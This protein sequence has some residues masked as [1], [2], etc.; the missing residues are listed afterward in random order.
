MSRDVS[1]DVAKG[2]AIVC[3]VLGHGDY[4]GAPEGMI[5]LIFTFHMPLFFILSG[6]FMSPEARPDTCYVRECALSLLLQYAVTCAIM[7]L[8]YAVRTLL[9]WPEGLLDVLSTMGVASLYGS[10]T[11]VVPLPDGV[12]MVGAI[13]FL[14]ALFWA[15]LILAAANR[16]PYP[17]AAVLCSFVVGYVSSDILWL[18]LDIQAGAC[19]TLFLYLG[20]RLREKDVLSP[21]S[22]N[23]L[24]WALIAGMWLICVTLGG[25]LTMAAN[26]YPNGPIVDVLGGLCGTLCVVKLSQLIARCLP[27]LGKPLAWLGTITLP[28]FC[29]HLVEMDVF[30]WDRVAEVL[31][32]LPMPLWVGALVVRCALIAVMCGV[33]YALP[34][35]ISGVFYRSR[36]RR[37]KT[38]R[39]RA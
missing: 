17:L 35:P 30:L 7:L 13:W 19:A 32:S 34:R 38:A 24:L 25:K 11:M 5:D 12:T 37:S 28:I 4:F 10:G 6:F 16:S 31:I 1:L 23:P 9:F 18:P 20:Q 21:G 22:L 39:M 36:G 29:M 8:L 33:L 15:K 27:A 14:L 3:V 2:I 26:Y